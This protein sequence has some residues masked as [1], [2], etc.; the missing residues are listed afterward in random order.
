[1]ASV[2]SYVNAV[3]ATDSAGKPN[4]AKRLFERQKLFRRGGHFDPLLVESLDKP[5]PKFR[6]THLKSLT[7]NPGSL[8][9]RI[10]LCP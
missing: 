7:G 1:M 10:N 8:L 3:L 5:L 9:V 6:K 2:P 4:H